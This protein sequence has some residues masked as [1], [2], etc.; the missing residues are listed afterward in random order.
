MYRIKK[1]NFA[2]RQLPRSGCRSSLKNGILDNFVKFTG[3]YQSFTG[4]FTGISFTGKF[5]GISFTEKFTGKYQSL[6]LIRLQ[7]RD[8]QLYLKRDPAQLNFAKSLRIPANI[9][10]R[11]IQLL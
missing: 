4:K 2:G 3:K 5:T 6:F 8:L 7:P 11:L 9:C 10:E 1:E